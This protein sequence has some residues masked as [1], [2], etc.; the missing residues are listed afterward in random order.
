M[1]TKRLK[2]VHAA[3]EVFDSVHEMAN[4]VERILV[5][6]KPHMIGGTEG[7][8]DR[9][10]RVLREILHD[11]GYVAMTAD[12]GDSW[13][14]VRQR[15]AGSGWSAHDLA[16]I[17]SAPASG[18]PH[19]YG[20]KAVV[21]ISFDHR[22]LGHVGFIPGLHDLT[23]AR[24]EGQAQQD[25]PGDP[26]DHVAASKKYMR[27]AAVVA[28]QH[29]RGGGL[30]FLTGDFNRIDRTHNLMY[31][32]DFLSCWDELRQWPDT[33]HGNIDAVIRMKSDR[34]VSLRSAQVLTDKELKLNSDHYLVVAEYDI[35]KLEI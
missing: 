30:A 16:V 26:V 19:P 13:G 17:P 27:A 32:D 7:G 31:N 28:N 1:S 9:R 15:L 10:K 29:A 20:T 12:R 2:I 6:T 3:L 22:T 11:H 14:G 21:S 18:D 34:R 24:Y 4:D 5:A 8:D 25:K 23:K 33:G 35:E